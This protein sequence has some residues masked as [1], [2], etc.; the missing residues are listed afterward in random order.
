MSDHLPV[1]LVVDDEG[2][3]RRLIT[4]LLKSE[5]YKVL[6]ASSAQDALDQM[7]SCHPDLVL[8]DGMMPG[9]SGFDLAA[10]IKSD[11][12][13]GTIPVVIVTALDDRAVRLRTLEAGVDDYLYKPI[14]RAELLVRVNNLLRLKE[15]SDHIQKSNERLEK[16]V[17]QR[18][19]QLQESYRQTIETLIRA[20]QKK[21]EET[22]SHLKRIAYYC[23]E[24]AIR[25]GM[26][27]DYTDLIFRASPMHD[28]GK[29]GI[30]DRI[31]LKQGPLDREEWAIMRTHTTLGANI[32]GEKNLSLELA[33]GYDIALGHHE[34]WDGCGYPLGRK[35]EEIPLCARIM[36]LA[37]VYDAL[38]SR[39][40]YKEPFDHD[41]SVA[42]IQ[43]G[44]GR[45]C[46]EQFDPQLLAIFPL[47]APAFAEYFATLTDTLEQ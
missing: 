38:R 41:L 3:S 30:P 12:R 18:T 46:P 35:G 22:G 13:Y 15:Y 9:I 23:K 10:K 4:A 45:V 36:A 20:A 37:D 33:M 19:I 39:R 29:I 47:V 26:T 28:V 34:R 44:D 32:I 21:D 27:A 7:E 6:T 5:P 14:D 11:P 17:H 40:P 43:K 42:I 2:S 25:L 16:A 24:L 8:T 31:L 1:V